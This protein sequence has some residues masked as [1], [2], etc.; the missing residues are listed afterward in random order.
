MT[1]PTAPPQQREDA[2]RPDIAGWARRA[3]KAMAVP[4]GSV[5][6]AFLIGAIIFAISGSDPVL[7]YQAM[8][9]GGFGLF[10]FGGETPAL[11]V[12]NTIFFL[13]PLIV[14]G[15]SV[16]FAF[17][18]GLFNIGVQGQ[19]IVGAILATIVGIRLGNWPGIVLIPLVLLAG[20]VGGAVWAG[21]AG[22]LKAMT[23]AH[24][25]VT[26][27]MLNYVAYNL[28]KFLVVNGPMQA[29]NS[30]A[31][32]LPVSQNAQLPTFI[33]ATSTFFGQPGGV[34]H[35]DWGL[36][37]AL[38]GAV[39]FFFIMRRMALGYEIRAVGQS[40]R[41]ARYAG[42][43][44]RRTIIVTMLISGAFA[45]LTGA[46]M[47]SGGAL[48]YLYSDLANDSTG[49]DGIAV[50]LLGLNSA[51]GVV[52]A[53]ILFGALHAGGSVMQSDAQISSRI[54]QI[55]QAVILFSLAANFLRTLK[56]RLPGP[57]RKVAEA[58]GEEVVQDE[59]QA[60]VS[61]AATDIEGKA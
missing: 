34:Y 39:I 22:V 45:G 28:L 12:A 5:I 48:H 7:A 50:A 44:V 36:L 21:I 30:S 53:S 57:G 18:A 3:A 4:I 2:V 54:V 51:I 47:I 32:S 33:P 40:Q 20:I 46:L 13:T 16:A 59:F 19:L 42:V 23:G 52:L 31:I 29:P 11:Q 26:T 27:I 37:I 17:R 49:F 1:A 43:S 35:V 10:C 6:F 56:L 15:L 55:L 25:V 8:A 14:A 41:A 38:A 9:C 60:E 61:S 24:E 58:S